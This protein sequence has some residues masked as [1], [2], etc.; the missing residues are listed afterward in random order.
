VKGIV[1]IEYQCILSAAKSQDA[2]RSSMT[3]YSIQGNQYGDHGI[4]KLV[5]LEM[6]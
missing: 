5:R 6:R 2:S 1:L 4:K 3:C